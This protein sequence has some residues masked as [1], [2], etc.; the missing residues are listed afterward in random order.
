MAK[1]GITNPIHVR[2]WFY[3]YG[4][5]VYHFD[6]GTKVKRGYPGFTSAGGLV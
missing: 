6:S 4:T 1:T 3:P 2:S 5:R